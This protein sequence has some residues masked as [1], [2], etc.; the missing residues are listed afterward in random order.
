MDSQRY[1]FYLISIIF[2]ICLLGLFIDSSDISERG[3]QNSENSYD[4]DDPDRVYSGSHSGTDKY[5]LTDESIDVYMCRDQSCENVYLRYLNSSTQTIHCAFF[6]FNLKRINDM[7]ESKSVEKSI[8]VDGDNM[9]FN[10]SYIIY[11]NKSSYMH[12]KFCIIDGRITITGSFN[13]TVNDERLNDNNVLV[14][15]SE[16]VSDIYEEYYHGLM[17]EHDSSHKKRY[18]MDRDYDLIVDGINISICFSRGG[19]CN[20]AI[21]EEI[22]KAN[23]TIYFMLFSL[24]EKRI[25]D[26]IIYSKYLGIDVF[27]IMEKGLITRYSSFDKLNFHIKNVKKDCNSAKLHHKVFIIDKKV[28]ITGSFNPGENAEDDNDENMIIIRDEGIAEKY[29]KEFNRLYD[30]CNIET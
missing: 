11:E 23:R 21:L 13:P 22:G 4:G 10:D 16:K 8:Y 18:R 15:E 14:L 6:D 5:N 30:W 20:D 9:D 26:S 27:G 3:Y 28:V 2:L 29:L 1:V 25:A 19:N 24:T 7:L 17:Q 12:N